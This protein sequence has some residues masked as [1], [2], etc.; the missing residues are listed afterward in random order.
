MD[1]VVIVHI[2]LPVFNLFLSGP[3]VI[4]EEKLDG[5]CYTKK[6]KKNGS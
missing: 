1:T 2:I 4:P 3:Y 5:M 6:K